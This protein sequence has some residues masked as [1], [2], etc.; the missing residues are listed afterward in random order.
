[1]GLRLVPGHD[2]AHQAER[3]VQRDQSETGELGL[4][5]RGLDHRHARQHHHDES[6]HD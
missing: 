4:V 5:R 2:H 1:M 6:A 3:Q